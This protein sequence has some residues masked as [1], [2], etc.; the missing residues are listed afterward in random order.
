MVL[1]LQQQSVFRGGIG[2]KT[3]N[4]V[5]EEKITKFTI[6]ASDHVEQIDINTDK[7]QS[8]SSGTADTSI[9]PYG[10]DMDVGS[11]FLAGFRA[12]YDSS[13]IY[14]LKPYFLDNY[15][16]TRTNNPTWHAGS[17]G[18][19]YPYE[20]VRLDRRVE[21][22]EGWWG[23]SDMVGGD[24]GNILRK[25]QVTYEGGG[26]AAA[27]ALGG[28]S[29]TQYKE[30]TFNLPEKEVITQFSKRAGMRTDQI[31]FDTDKPGIYVLGGVGGHYVS[32]PDLGNGI[33]LGF[34]GRAG[35]DINQLAPVFAK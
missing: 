15:V 20:M 27:G 7:G 33:L 25:I 19:G 31:W 30:Y 32:T 26:T 18:G 11:G 16:V 1:T 8:I 29:P 17:D 4:L 22:V 23:A 2:P 12:A 6:W 5:K 10:M 14:R 9:P 3:I 13:K 28:A 24:G 35:W 34:E 21:K